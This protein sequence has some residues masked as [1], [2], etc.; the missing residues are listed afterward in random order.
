MEKK[1]LQKLNKEIYAQYNQKKKFLVDVKNITRVSVVKESPEG[2]LVEAVV[3]S[4]DV[5]ITFR[6]GI[7][8]AI[9][10][11]AKN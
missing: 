8:I 5:L 3:V 4:V 9:L 7:I 1:T 10:T 2:E 11:L 6:P